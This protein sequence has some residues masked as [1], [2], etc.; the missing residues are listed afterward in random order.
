MEDGVDRLV[1][2]APGIDGANANVD[3]Q[4]GQWDEPSIEWFIF[5]WTLEWRG[6][7]LWH[8]FYRSLFALGLN[9][10]AAIVRAQRESA[11]PSYHD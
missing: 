2:R 3:Q 10:A 8:G 4:R 1:K 11:C 9:V 5:G 7:G 6:G